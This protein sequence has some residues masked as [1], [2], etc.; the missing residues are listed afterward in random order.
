MK[1]NVIMC[2]T[3][4]FCLKVALIALSSMFCYS[5]N[6]QKAQLEKLSEI[7]DV[8][9]QHFDKDAMKHALDNDFDIQLGDFSFTD[10]GKG[11]I[12][13]GLDEIYVLTTEAKSAGKKL[14]KGAHKILKGKEFSSLLNV[15]GEEG[16]RV[17][18]CTAEENGKKVLAILVNSDDGETVFVILKGTIDMSKLSSEMISNLM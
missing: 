17:Q 2:T 10:S 18:I 15:G 6:A 14:S 13:K 12:L 4:N 3:I 16:G 5:L 7:K 11:D 8:Q 1:T 9:Y